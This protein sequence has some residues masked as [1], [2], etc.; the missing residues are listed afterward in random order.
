[1]SARRLA[2]A[3]A[4]LALT[5]AA[6]GPARAD[7]EIQWQGVSSGSGEVAP[8][9]EFDLDFGNLTQSRAEFR[10]ERTADGIY[11]VPYIVRP[12]MGCGATVVSGD[13]EG[14][15]LGKTIGMNVSLERIYLCGGASP[16]L[17]AGTLLYVSTCEGN[18]AKVVLDEC[19]STVKFRYG[20][21]H[22][23][24]VVKAPVSGALTPPPLKC[25]PDGVVFEHD[26]RVLLLAWG[27]VPGAATYDLDVDCKGCCGP[28][29]ELWC[30]EQE[31]G[32]MFSSKTALTSPEY[33]TV[34]QGALPGRW[35]TRA[36]KADGS[37]GPWT[38]WFGFS[39]SK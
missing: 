20:S 16:A 26:P 22:K 35:R 32:G 33:D 27:R 38:G 30:S 7:T 9:Q 18:T 13:F 19:G 15:D 4:I 28:R 21:Y 36:V 6:P 1:M 11:W 25:P 24:T 10:I 29:R 23:Q 34:W 17:P 31:K 39:F 12:N 37:A 8:G 5:A 2:L 14:F 3:A